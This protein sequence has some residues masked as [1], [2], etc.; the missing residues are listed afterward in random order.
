MWNIVGRAGEGTVK[1]VYGLRKEGPE[2]AGTAALTLDD[3]EGAI[4]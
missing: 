1:P 3:G 4:I 2:R